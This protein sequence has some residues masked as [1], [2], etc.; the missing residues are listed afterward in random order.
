MTKILSEPTYRRFIT[1]PLKRYDE[2]NN[3]WSRADKGELPG[4]GKVMEQG[5]KTK[6]MKN[7]RGYTRE[8]YA[9]S[10][11]ARAVDELIRKGAFGRDRQV[12][13]WA[14]SVDKMPVRDRA[15]VS[16]TVKKTARW[17]GADLVGICELNPLWVYSHWGHG[18]LSSGV[19]KWGDPVEVPEEYRYAVV[20]AWAMPYDDV[21]RSPA[22]TP[23]T[24][25]GYAM[26]DF[27]AASVAEFIRGLGYKAIPYGNEVALNI[28]LAIDAGLGELGR[29]G[30]L[31]TREYGPRV[32]LS[33]VFTDLPLEADKPVDIGIQD[34]CEKCTECARACPGRAILD[35]ER[36]DQ[37][38]NISNSSGVLKWPTDT[39][40]C[41]AFWLKNGAFCMNC[42]K[43][44]PWNRP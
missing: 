40:K 43:V 38:R 30:L 37:P 41:S 44:C 6:A 11:G 15:K 10:F 42:I 13:R 31:I 33:K 27:V 32:R 28:P 9:L 14:I 7:I 36:T 34:F 5:L 4:S 25:F 16:E 39:E 21:M 2:R 20:I 22:H 29:S 1:G 24:D 17:L 19:A 3:A 8:D 18:A 35:G 26:A 12:M 23:C